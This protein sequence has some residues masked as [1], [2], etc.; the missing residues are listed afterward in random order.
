MNRPQQVLNLAD[1]CLDTPT[2]EHEFLHAIGVFHEQNR[3]DRKKYVTIIKGNIIAKYQPNFDKF[4]LD[5]Y[6]TP[7]DYKSVIRGAIGV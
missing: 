4:N 6:G 3:P 5:T 2:I 7:Y 1:E